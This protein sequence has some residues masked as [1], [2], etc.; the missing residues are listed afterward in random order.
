MDNSN[1]QINKISSFNSLEDLYNSLHEN[2]I[3][4]SHTHDWIVDGGELDITA[5]MNS[6]NITAAYTLDQDPLLYTLTEIQK[7]KERITDASDLDDLNAKEERC[8]QALI[9]KIK[10]DQSGK[11]SYNILQDEKQF[12]YLK[13]NFSELFN[14]AKEGA[15][16][17][18]DSTL[19]ELNFPRSYEEFANSNN[20]IYDQLFDEIESYNELVRNVDKYYRAIPNRNNQPKKIFEKGRQETIA[21]VK[22]LLD[23]KKKL[24]KD[25]KQDTGTKVV[26]EDNASTET[27]QPA[28]QSTQP[29]QKHIPTYVAPKAPA[30]IPGDAGTTPT[31]DPTGRITKKKKSKKVNTNETP[32]TMDELYDAVNNLAQNQPAQTTKQE[33]PVQKPSLQNAIDKAKTNTT[34]NTPATAVEPEE[35]QPSVD[36]IMFNGAYNR[37]LNFN[38]GK[39]FLLYQDNPEAFKKLTKEQKAE[40]EQDISENLN[41]ISLESLFEFLR[42]TKKQFKPDSELYQNIVE[43]IIDKDQTGYN[44]VRL[45]KSGFDIKDSAYKEEALRKTM[46]WAEK[47]PEDPTIA[48]KF[49]EMIQNL[50]TKL[51]DKFGKK[52]DLSLDDKTQKKDDKS[53]SIST[54]LK[55][56]V[57][58]K[59]EDQ[60]KNVLEEVQNKVKVAIENDDTIA[61]ENKSKAIETAMFT[62]TYY[63]EQQKQ[64]FDLLADAFNKDAATAWGNFKKLLPELR[65]QAI[66]N[67]YSTDPIT[68]T[69][70]FLDKRN[71]IADNTTKIA[72]NFIKKYIETNPEQVQAYIQANK[73][74]EK[75]PNNV[76]PEDQTALTTLEDAC[77]QFYTNFKQKTQQQTNKNTTTQEEKDVQQEPLT[78]EVIEQNIINILQKQNFN[79]AQLT[80]L[81][82]VLPAVPTGVIAN[83][84]SELHKNPE[85]ADELITNLLHEQFELKKKFYNMQ[86]NQKRKELEE[87]NNKL[88]QEAP[89]GPE[90]QQQMFNKDTSIGPKKSSQTTMLF[91]KANFVK[92]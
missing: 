85:K 17:Y 60:R 58:P 8:K 48:G 78:R 16:V 2:S 50:Y 45:F 88:G 9:S 10:N 80:T 79:K 42:K 37:K 59:S 3:T 31:T 4:A 51:K 15:L 67:G 71:M 38:A 11:Y 25:G 64:Q 73:N 75:D 83:I 22:K 12:N 57:K 92:K 30:A 84:Y 6:L 69:L 49:L 62:L 76:S 86:L 63:Y 1:N 23:F 27:A 90:Q 40:A 5:T 20:P 32:A 26:P 21:K 77:K 81:Q 39:Y 46:L 33:T 53:P 68:Q 35:A 29:E 24:E 41:N 28:Q 36:D 47:N 44:C 34:T 56:L 87:Q 61:K 52:D 91:V 18:I 43:H 82:E 7:R 19:Q 14:K 70:Y 54:F 65:K 13:K 72:F 74:I 66:K 55:N 89:K